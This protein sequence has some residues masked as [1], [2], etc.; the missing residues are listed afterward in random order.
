MRNICTLL[1]IFI[2]SF[3]LHAQI[4]SFKVT[5]SF[6][7]DMSAS[8]ISGSEAVIASNAVAGGTKVGVV[9]LTT[10][11]DQKVLRS[12]IIKNNNTNYINTFVRM[13][14]K[15]K[16]GYT[17]V[18]RSVTANQS[19]SITNSLVLFRIGTTKNQ[20][21]PNN[22]KL[23]ESLPNTVLK[24]TFSKNIFSPAVEASQTIGQ[25]SA[26]VWLCARGGDNDIYDWHLNSVEIQGD[27]IQ[28]GTE[29]SATVVLTTT[30]KQKLRF[31]IDAERL[32]YWQTGTFGN[33]L[34]NLGVKELQSAF[35]RVAIDCAYEREEGVKKPELYNK[36]LDMMTAMKTANPA[37]KFFASPRPLDEAYTDAERQSIWGGPKAPWAPVPAWIMT[38]VENGTTIE[39]GQTIKKWKIGTIYVDKLTRYYADYL[40]FMYSKGFTIDYMDVTN[41]KNEITATHCKY[42]Y[43]NLPGMLN[44]GVPMPQLIAFSAWSYEQSTNALTAFTPSQLGSFAIASAH[45]TGDDGTPAAFV[46]QANAIGKEPWNTELHEWVG[47]QS[48]EEIVN[49]K[50]FFEAMKGGFVGL[51]SWLFY[52]PKEGKDHTMIWSGVTNG[53]SVVE[54][55]TKYEIFK[56]VV[57]NANGGNYREVTSNSS[58][59][60]T[61][62]FVKDTVLT[63]W[64][65]NSTSF[66]MPNVTFTFQDT[67][68]STTSI[69][70]TEWQNALPRSGVVTPLTTAQS[71]GFSYTLDP[72]SLYCFKIALKRDVVIVAGIEDKQKF[73]PLTL[74][75]NPVSHKL[76]VQFP[77]FTPIGAQYTILNSNGRMVQKGKLFSSAVEVEGLAPGL[78][79]IQVSDRLGNAYMSRFVKQ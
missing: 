20:I 7:T 32:W 60:L 61:A 21:V 42:I 44:P 58:G 49:S 68:V 25:D 48:Q 57:N 78:Y 27:Y 39:N 5:Y 22:T 24:S 65:L 71:T 6:D 72:A 56:K 47:I 9:G 43:D 26:T 55:S 66:T 33:T 28:T 23:G 13:N 14:I 34:A 77:D 41:E 64:A 18:I 69:E 62:G 31:G 8:F 45:N 36:I 10:V 35:V 75:P 59:L 4:K 17:L 51:C 38:H 12:E 52:G 37:I 53:T 63:V 50:A 54:K 76:T 73:Q 79:L 74:Y 46:A 30:N 15:P 40:N 29:P 70:V 19:S 1:L 67:K 2:G 3:Q 16:P 11:S